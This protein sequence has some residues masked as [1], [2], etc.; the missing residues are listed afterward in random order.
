MKKIGFIDYFLDEWHA[1]NYPVWI[2]ENARLKGRDC[3]LAYA[4]AKTENPRGMDT[5]AWCG[6]YGV[7]P[8]SSIEE[9]V[10]KSDYILVLSPDN[11]EQHEMLSRIPLMSGKPVYIDKTFSPDLASGARMFELAEKHNTPMFSSS[12][13]RFASELS[14]FPDSEVNNGTLEYVV[15]IGP[16][17]YENYSIHQIEMIVTLMGTGAERIKSMSSDNGRLLVLEYKNSR[18]ASMIQMQQLPFQISLQL[19]DGNNIFINQCSDIFP[20]LIDS[21]LDFFETCKPAVP[22][23]ET[24]EVMAIREAG[25]KA[26]NS[27]DTW[28]RI[29]HV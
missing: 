3:D 26:L 7:A 19:R 11:P 21:M 23:E 1:N 8:L 24:L 12:A 27:Y 22:R 16:G 28:I 29:Q 4:F 10:D 6:K 5:A 13:L 9:L 15:T 2:R 20:R 25:F 17:A 18:R 14:N